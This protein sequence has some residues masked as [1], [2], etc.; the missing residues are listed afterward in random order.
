MAAGGGLWE[1]RS[2][3]GRARE[4]AEV[5]GL[6]QE[7]ARLVVVTGDA[8]AG[9]SA[10]A[11]QV[12]DRFAEVPGRWSDGCALGEVEDLPGVRGAVARA[13]AIPLEEPNVEGWV[14]RIGRAL[15]GRGR[16][17]LVL[18]DVEHLSAKALSVMPIWLEAAPQ[19]Q[20]LATSRRG[21]ALPSERRV[22]LGPLHPE[23]A[24]ALFAA[25]RGRP[26]DPQALDRLLDAVDRLPLGIEQLAARSVV[27]G[28]TLLSDQLAD[29]SS[30]AH[31]G[32]RGPLL[33][34]SGLPEAGRRALLAVA[35][36]PG[37]FDVD[38]A[39]IALGGG[40]GVG[41]LEILLEHSVVWADEGRDRAAKLRVYRSARAF[42]LSCP[43]YPEARDRVLLALADRLIAESPA[44]GPVDLPRPTQLAERRPLG[45]TS[46]L[47]ANL[48]LLGRMDESRARAVALALLSDAHSRGDLPTVRRLLD[49]A[50]AFCRQ[51]ALDRTEARLHL[52]MAM[53]KMLFAEG[54]G[55]HVDVALAFEGGPA[56]E[57][58][59]RLARAE[60]ALLAPS[61][62]DPR[63]RVREA[64][65]DLDVA[66]ARFET[67]G[68]RIGSG[69]VAMSRGYALRRL[70]D[71]AAAEA[72]LLGATDLL[73][74][75]GDLSG[76]RRSTSHLGVLY[77]EQGRL[78]EAAPTARRSV[79]LA[80]HLSSSVGDVWSLLLLGMC[81]VELGDLDEAETTLRG[82]A[83]QARR[84]GYRPMDVL[85][86]GLG[87]LAASVGDL[88][89]A[90]DAF[91][92]AIRICDRVGAPLSRAYNEA[93]LGAVLWAQGRRE[94]AR[95]LLERS[96]AGLRGQREGAS[97]P[98]AA[99]L[100]RARREDVRLDGPLAE[101]ESPC[102]RRFVADLLAASSAV[103]PV[104]APGVRLTLPQTGDAFRLGDG[105]VIGLGR[106]R[107]AKRVLVH[108]ASRH[109]ANPGGC[110]DAFE[111]FEA[112]W[113]G[114]TIRPDSAAHRVYVTLSVLRKLGLQEVI[115]TTDDGYR[116][117]NGLAIHWGTP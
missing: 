102:D 13:L 105:P 47:E 38:A 31:A 2:F 112:G 92:E 3:V 96:V 72:A 79:A 40:D 87:K 19:L 74:N 5:E 18:D 63:A 4:I 68:D 7:G 43:G 77:V 64:L 12:K 78:D 42:A 46:C 8:G 84:A 32:A 33:S 37:A 29:V 66:A 55:D 17:L 70:G 60:L 24:R 58:W 69:R 11:R 50:T 73:R 90:E 57:G 62:G 83:T 117:A 86:T 10:M 26:A 67:V 51:P 36:F 61:G 34:W 85:H 100:G 21:L 71:S 94:D 41:L 44:D 35:C 111:L 22:P 82:V 103:H 23:E 14:A 27:F 49:A 45:L 1:P 28:V 48:P 89:A 95:R 6:L 88:A 76:E 20:L 65:R 115:V 109:E 114:E 16:G 99:L 110:S 93:W 30:A 104:A 52:G 80:Q 81:Q 56:H 75:A 116:L 53:G 91:L 98:F 25:R 97:R 59:G 39:A 113:P 107:A 101:G 9:K 54:G 106:R 108:L 15:A